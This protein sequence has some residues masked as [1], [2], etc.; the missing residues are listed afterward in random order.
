MRIKCLLV[1]R[2]KPYLTSISQPNE[3]IPRKHINCNLVF[4]SFRIYFKL[5]DEIKNFNKDI[6]ASLSI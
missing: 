6:I 5:D 4:G 3:L 1:I 2:K